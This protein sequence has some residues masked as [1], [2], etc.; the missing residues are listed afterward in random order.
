MRAM[1]AALLT[2]RGYGSRY[3]KFVAEKEQ[4]LLAEFADLPS[5]SFDTP[6]L[7]TIDG[8]KTKSLID[9]ITDYQNNSV[10]QISCKTNSLAESLKHAKWAGA[11][12]KV[13]QG[14]SPDRWQVLPREC[15]LPHDA[16]ACP[17]LV[18]MLKNHWCHCPNA[19]PTPGLGGFAR[20]PDT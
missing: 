1:F 20:S 8:S 11:M 19:W 6:K 5:A 18:C 14:E 13:E 17:W 4:S 9:H 15:L 3:W 2:Q 16:G 7:W 12:A 10:T